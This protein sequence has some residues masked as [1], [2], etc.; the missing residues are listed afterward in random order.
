MMRKNPYGKIAAAILLASSSNGA[1][2]QKAKDPNVV[3]VPCRDMGDGRTLIDS[4]Y[5]PDWVDPTK[6]T[7]SI[8]ERRP[9]SMKGEWA[10]FVCTI[11][12]TE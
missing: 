12:L 9:A 2:A 4:L 11:K 5:L 7:W 3:K 10:N 1:L 6:S 8:L